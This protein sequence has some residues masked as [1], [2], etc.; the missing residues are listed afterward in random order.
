MNQQMVEKIADAILYEGYMLY[1][2]RAS[3]IKNRQ[4][5]NFGVLAPPAYSEAQRGSENF[6]MQTQC[7]ISGEE[8]VSIDIKI[9]FLQLREREIYRGD[10]ISGSTR[11]ESLTI[12][13]ETYQ[14]WQEALEREVDITEIDLGALAGKPRRVE[15]SFPENTESEAL[16]DANGQT[17]GSIVRKRSVI[18]GTADITSELLEKGLFKLTICV[19]NSTPFENASEKSRDEA[20]ASSLVSAHTI[21]R[22]NKG[23]FISLLEPPA[24][25][26]DAAASCQNHATFPV[27]VGEEGELNTMLSSPI[28]LYDYPEIAAESAGELFDGTEIDEILTLRIMTMTDAEKQEMRSVDERARKILERTETMAP[29]EFMKL[30]GVLRRPRALVKE[31]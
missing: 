3:A 30:H 22:G 13:G 24:E 25:Y 4:R 15:F 20:L 5:F 19:S 14:S 10:I 26:I 17:V 28:I 2:Y 12:D 7:L 27:L 21:I 31:A 18:N 8:N 1:P 9:R 11:V 23:I 16:L 6:Q 29:E